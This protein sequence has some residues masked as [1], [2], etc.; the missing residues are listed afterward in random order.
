MVKPMVMALMVLFGGHAMAATK[1]SEVAPVSTPDVIEKTQI[2]PVEVVN[3]SVVPNNLIQAE[4]QASGLLGILSSEMMLQKGQ[5]GNA[6]SSY[7]YM[8]QS[9][10]DPKVAERAVDIALAI[11]DLARARLFLAQ[12]RQLEPQP[13]PAQV[14]AQWEYD[15]MTQQL[16]NV[17][18]RL[19][20]VLEDASL[21]QARRIFLYMAQL[22]VDNTDYSRQGYPAVH[23]AAQKYPE[24]EEAVMAEAIYAGLSGKTRASIAGLTKLAQLDPMLSP[25][26]QVTLSLLANKVPG[27]LTT[28][29][30]KVDARDLSYGWQKLQVDVLLKANKGNEAYAKM[31]ELLQK[32]QDNADLYVEAGYIAQQLQRPKAEVRAHFDRAYDLGDAGQKNKVAMLAG[33]N[34]LDD[35]DVASAKVWLQKVEGTRYAFDKNIYLTLIALKEEAYADAKTYLAAAKPHMAQGIVFNEADWL[36]ADLMLLHSQKPAPEVLLNHLTRLIDLEMAKGQKANQAVLAVLLYDRGIIYADRLKQPEVA[37]ADFAKV[38]V[39]QPKDAETLNA[40]GYTMLSIPGRLNDAIEHI[41]AAYVLSPNSPTVNDSLGWA[42]FLQ[43]KPQAA[44][45]YLKVAYDRFPDTEV[46]LHYVEVLWQLGK[47]REAQVIV[48]KALADPESADKVQALMQRLAKP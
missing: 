40:M 10:K 17:F 11:P 28:F 24:L 41:E 15:L 26:S 20:A 3:T 8:L 35:D 19:P 36:R 45:P 13:S 18:E 16:N 30:S 48:D 23:K 21:S 12:W 33:V 29:F 47:Y 7:G 27:L 1:P 32:E 39:W 9:T 46:V 6:L 5:V 14:R 31:K 42:Y 34:A 38:L 2:G 43:G 25:R 22:T 4:R 37:I 44:E